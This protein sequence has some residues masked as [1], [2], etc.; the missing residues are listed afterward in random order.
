MKTNIYFVRHALSTYTP[1]E[2]GRP[3][4]DKGIADAAKISEVLAEERVD[5]FISSPY[6][7]AVQTIQGAAQRSDQDIILMD[8]FKER[9]L[10]EKPV[11]NFEQAIEKVWED[12]DFSWEGGESNLAAQERGVK[13]LLEV[14]EEYE[15]KNIVIGTHGNIMVLIMNYFNAHFDFEFW[16]QLEMP[17]IYRLSFEGQRLTGTERLM[18]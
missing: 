15:G 16:K 3:L 5:V 6:L 1:D 14:L 8:G 11:E 2:L 4:S 12:W 9:T 13:V 7:R 17:D 10:S 18:K